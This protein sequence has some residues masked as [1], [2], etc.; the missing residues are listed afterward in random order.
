LAIVA[1]VSPRRS[2]RT[3]RVYCANCGHLLYKYRK[4][5]AGRLVKCFQDRIV[6]DNTEGDLDCP[7][8]GQAFARETMA[9]GRP[10]NKII[11][12]KV[13]VRR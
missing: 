8:C 13:T 11:Q 1:D 3:I 10:A 9:Y 5:G 7:S 6:Q 12:R 4:S 2:A